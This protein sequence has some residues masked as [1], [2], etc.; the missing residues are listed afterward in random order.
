MVVTVA[1][2]FRLSRALFAALVALLAFPFTPAHAQ[3][4]TRYTVCS[5]GPLANCGVLR[6]DAEYGAGPGGTTRYTVG[7]QNLGSQAN[8]SMATSIYNLTFGTE[9]PVAT[10]GTEVDVLIAPTAVGGAS[11]TD[12]SEWSLFDAGD[13]IFL[14]ALTNNGVGGCIASLPIDPFGQAGQTCGPGQFLSF[15][16]FSPRTYDLR[17]FTLLD[18]EAVGL[19]DDLPADSCGGETQCTI[20]EAT[21]SPEPGTLLLTITG[22]LGTMSHSMRRRRIAPSSSSERRGMA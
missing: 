14:S 16:F 8:P 7:V 17:S 12:P 6:W 13:A 18:Y 19:T 3:A 1:G 15:S 5:L 11:I 10:L 2:D 9:R 4:W 20:T 21:S 22:L